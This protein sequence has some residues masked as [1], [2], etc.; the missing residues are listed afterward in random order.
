MT[1]FDALMNSA[2]VYAAAIVAIAYI[3]RGIAGFG[4]GLIAIPLLVLIGI[5]LTVVVP[6]IVLLDYLASASHGLSHRKAIVWREILPLLPFTLLGVFTALYLY[7]AVD[8][9]LLTM[10]LGSFIII[11]AIY[12]L[13][14][15]PFDQVFSRIWAIPAGGLGGLLGTLFGTGGPFYVIYLQL[16]GLDKTA[17]RATFATIF[18]IDGAN[19]LAGYF[20][21]GFFGSASIDLILF[22]LPVMAVSLYIGGHIHVK[23]EQETFKRAIS[24]LLLVS[25][26]LL[27]FK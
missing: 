5:P 10:F 9:H 3:V 13:L 8:V 19:R 1:M 14:A 18:L 20:V 22:M 27:L 15:E 25:G 16:R 2:T 24:A 26:T 17:F 11:Y 12:T 21:A 4:S 6:M 23:F 7:K